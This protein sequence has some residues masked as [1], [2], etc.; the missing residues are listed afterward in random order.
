MKLRYGTL[1]IDVDTVTASLEDGALKLL[2]EGSVVSGMTAEEAGIYLNHSGRAMEL[3]L[4]SNYVVLGL[5]PAVASVTAE[6]E[7]GEKPDMLAVKFEA[8]GKV[9]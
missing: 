4:P 2:C 5:P 8:E 3:S 1:V 7:P 6:V 9:E